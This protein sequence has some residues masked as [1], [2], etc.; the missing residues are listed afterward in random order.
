MSNYLFAFDIQDQVERSIPLENVTCV[1]A[2]PNTSSE[3]QD[4]DIYFKQLSTYTSGSGE[5]AGPALTRVRITILKYQ[6]SE[7]EWAAEVAS[8]ITEAIANPNSRIELIPKDKNALMTIRQPY[9]EE[10]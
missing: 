9:P 4:C 8:A 1:Y 7:Q 6:R 5:L 2:V 3:R 10:I